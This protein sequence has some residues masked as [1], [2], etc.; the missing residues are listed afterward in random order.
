MLPQ[1]LPEWMLEFAATAALLS[2]Y[3]VENMVVNQ[4]GSRLSVQPV[5]KREFDTVLRMARGT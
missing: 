5:T 3:G 4:K 1:T 2:T